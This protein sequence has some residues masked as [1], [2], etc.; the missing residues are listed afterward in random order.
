[1]SNLLEY[2]SYYGTVEFSSDDNILYGKVIGINSLISYEG[3]CVE[4]LKEDF[5]DVIDDYLELCKENG[6]EPEKIYKGSFNVRISP[7]LHK[8]LVIYSESHGQSLNST[9]EEAIKQ[10]VVGD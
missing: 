1:M 5:E 8:N 6:L 9:V 10:Y 7:D 4:S 3:E 2:K